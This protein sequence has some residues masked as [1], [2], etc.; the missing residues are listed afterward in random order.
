MDAEIPA[1]KAGVLA[2]ILVQ[3]GQTVAVQTVVARIETDAGARRGRPRRRRPGCRRRRPRRQRRLPRPRRAAAPPPP[4]PRHPPP[5]PRRPRPATGGAETPRSGS[6]ASTPLV[7][8]MA[9]EHGLDISA[10]SPAAASAGR[11]TKNDVLRYIESPPPRPRRR[12]AASAAGPRRHA[13][14]ARI[15][16]AARRPATRRS[17][18]GKATG[19][20]RGAGSGSSPPIT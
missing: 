15:G 16:T 12:A 1:P 7:R 6:A 2:E 3:E 18:R 13:A 8:K 11:V 17:S 19:S 4:A 14:A 10:P 9:A 5:A 20:S